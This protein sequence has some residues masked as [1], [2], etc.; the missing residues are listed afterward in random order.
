MPV[1]DA[2]PLGPLMELRAQDGQNTFTPERAAQSLD[3]W[4]NAAQ[5]ILSDPEAAGSPAA[6]LRA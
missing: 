4:R 2:L 6:S 3:Y 1:G 5:Q